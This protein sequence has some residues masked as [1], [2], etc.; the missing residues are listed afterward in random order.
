MDEW[1]DQFVVRQQIVQELRSLSYLEQWRLA[2]ENEWYHLKLEDHSLFLFQEGGASCSFTFLQC[3]LE[4][5]SFRE[6][7]VGGLRI[8]YDRENRRTH[9]QEYEMALETAALKEYISPM[10]YDRD[11]AGYRAGVHPL[12]HMHIGLGNQVRIALRR[13][14][15]AESFLLF[16]M[17]QQYP[18]CWERLLEH[19]VALKLA[20]R[21]RWNCREVDDQWWTDIDQAE[22]SLN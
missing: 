5:P 20:A 11:P 18:S 8:P 2:V 1:R 16:V 4:V 15:S 7:L 6:Y 12:G 21:I 13:Q 10:R 17:R 14:I 3:P 9:A 19:H 22:F